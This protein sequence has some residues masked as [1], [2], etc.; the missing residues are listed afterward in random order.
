VASS[1]EQWRA[2]ASSGEQ[3]RA[4]ASSGKQCQA[5]SS[6]VEQCSRSGKQC[7]AVSSSVKQCRA[8]SSSVKQFRTVSIIRLLADHCR[9]SRSKT[10]GKKAD[11][12]CTSKRKKTNARKKQIYKVKCLTKS[13]QSHC[14]EQSRDYRRISYIF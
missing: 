14:V 12:V 8:V 2:V 5:V 11:G 1:G 6:S 10:V 9:K 13:K 3:W 7:R 4:V